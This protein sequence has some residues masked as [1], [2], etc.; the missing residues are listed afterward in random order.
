MAKRILIEQ[1][2]LTVFAPRQLPED[3]YEAMHHT[4]TRQRLRARL[5]HAMRKV[6]RRYHTLSKVK[7]KVSL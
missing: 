2:H 7:V 6:C 3:E 1:F 5:Q 4:L